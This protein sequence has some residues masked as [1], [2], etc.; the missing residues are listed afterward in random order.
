META[1]ALC[2]FAHFTSVMIIFGAGAYAWLFSPETLRRALSPRLRRPLIALGLVGVV[3]AF[4]WLALEGAEMGGDW[5]DALDT[6]VLTDVLFSTSFGQVWQIRLPLTLAL[7]AALIFDRRDSWALT[8]CLAAGAAASLGLVGH[9]A[10]QTGGIGVLHR[11]NHAVHLLTASAWVGG[12]FPFVLCLRAYEDTAYRREA[13][14]AMMRFSTLGHVYVLVVV[15][16]GAVNIALTSRVLPWPPTSPYRA[17]LA[18]K[19]ALVFAMIGI[20]VFN[21]YALVPRVNTR[22]ASLG[23]LRQTSLSEIITAFVVIGL[24]SLLGLLNPT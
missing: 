11:A 2:R 21:R 9:A 22:E 16:T 17:L 20:A 8:T 5:S 14:T 6:E 1:L 15:A 3:S 10:M 23:Y 13:V 12:L 24:V 19:I 4:V 7:A 18:I